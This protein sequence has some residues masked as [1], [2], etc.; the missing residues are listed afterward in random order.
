VEEVVLI[1]PQE[2]MV[3]AIREVQVLGRKVQLRK[4]RRMEERVRVVIG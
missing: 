3:K 4:Y 2:E 1:L